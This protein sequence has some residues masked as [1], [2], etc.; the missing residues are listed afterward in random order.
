MQETEGKGEKRMTRE[1]IHF[2][3]SKI[4]SFKYMAKNYRK[5]I[6]ISNS[7]KVKIDEKEHLLAG[8]RSPAISGNGARAR[9]TA[10]EKEERRLKIVEEINALDTRKKQ[11][12]LLLEWVNNQIW[13][14][15]PELRYY[16]YRLTVLGTTINAL[17]D[18]KVKDNHR[19]SAKIKQKLE[20]V[21][22]DED[23]E[24]LERSINEDLCDE[25]YEA[26]FA[27]SNKKN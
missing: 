2:G 19:V 23:I 11:I 12:D 25:D 16:C 5:L 26:L 24:I 4:F 17:K 22:T 20:K 13:K 14:L 18:S 27:K 9:R 1:E 15:P 21:I 7:L 10:A 3:G 6:V 8:V